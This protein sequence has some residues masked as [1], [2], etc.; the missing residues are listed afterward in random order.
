MKGC[1]FM[2]TKFKKISTIL[3]VLTLIFALSINSF[4]TEV[5]DWDSLTPEEQEGAYFVGGDI[6]YE[7]QENEEDFEPLYN[8][9]IRP[10]LPDGFV[11]DIN[12]TF[13]N[14]DTN[15]TYSCSFDESNSYIVFLSIPKGEYTVS[16]FSVSGDNTG[17]YTIK[18]DEHFTLGSRLSVSYSFE[19]FDTTVIPEEEKVT[20]M[21]SALVE[22]TSG[23]TEN[24]N[25]TQQIIENNSQE[26]EKTSVLSFIVPAIF[27]VLVIFL[28]INKKKEKKEANDK[29][30][31]NVDRY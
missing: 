23:S 5:L 19:V 12:I 18:N 21:D 30:K 28:Y 27:L 3:L 2:P 11:G 6:P 24:N 13:I 25:S 26:K 7:M 10:K 4:A 29:Q 15:R 22:S 14:R 31:N 17:K 20:L 16:S 9:K 8:V 1:A